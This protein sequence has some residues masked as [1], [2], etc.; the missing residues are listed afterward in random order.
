MNISGVYVTGIQRKL[1]TPKTVNT[2]KS[3]PI[4]KIHLNMRTKV[5]RRKNLSKV[6]DE[7]SKQFVNLGM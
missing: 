3:N 1:N 4:R 5:G 6:I 7:D 2:R